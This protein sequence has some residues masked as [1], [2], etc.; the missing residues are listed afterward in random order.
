MYPGLIVRTILAQFGHR[1]GLKTGAIAEL[2]QYAKRIANHGSPEAAEQTGFERGF[3]HMIL[4]ELM[5]M[6]HR[7]QRLDLARDH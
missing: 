6:E 2:D 4:D 5:A 3:E 1:V 7:R